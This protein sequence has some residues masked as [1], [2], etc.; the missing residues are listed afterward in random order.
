[1]KAVGQFVAGVII[2]L[3]VIA[4]MNKA[5]NVTVESSFDSTG[6][7]MTTTDGLGNKQTCRTIIVG[8]TVKT[9]CN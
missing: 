9:V 3:V 8:E 5:T 7:T 1:M 2:F 6:G 4:Y